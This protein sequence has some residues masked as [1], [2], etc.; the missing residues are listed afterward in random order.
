MNGQRVASKICWFLLHTTETSH[1]LEHPTHTTCQ[2]RHRAKP[3]ERALSI[4]VRRITQC[5][6]LTATEKRQEQTG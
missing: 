4:L 1:L 5:G 2:P 3:A 6:A